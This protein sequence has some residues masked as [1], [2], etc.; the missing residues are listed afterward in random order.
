[1]KTSRH[2]SPPGKR[3]IKSS[4]SVNLGDLL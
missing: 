1:V 2:L 3:F 4:W